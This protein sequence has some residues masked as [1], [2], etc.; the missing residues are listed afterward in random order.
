MILPCSTT[1]LLNSKSM[2]FPKGQRER[3]EER[4]V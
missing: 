3:S 1:I 4:R 2:Q